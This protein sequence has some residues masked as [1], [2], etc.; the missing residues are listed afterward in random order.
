VNEWFLIIGSLRRK[1]E[2]MRLYKKNIDLLGNLGG[3]LLRFGVTQDHSE[4]LRRFKDTLVPRRQSNTSGLPVYYSVLLGQAGIFWHLGVTHVFWGCS[5]PHL[6]LRVISA[7]LVLVG[8]S[9]TRIHS[10]PFRRF[11]AIIA[12][13]LLRTSTLFWSRQGPLCC[14]NDH[15]DNIGV[16]RVYS[17]FYWLE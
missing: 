4:L 15:S 1:M 17:V 5:A 10:G 6:S 12:S 7:I 3:L 2:N 16:T 14:F 11:L 13:E 9:E 8:H